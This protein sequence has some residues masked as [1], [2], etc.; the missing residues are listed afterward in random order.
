M[1]ERLARKHLALGTIC[2]WILFGA[3][4]VFGFGTAGVGSFTGGLVFWALC[5]LMLLLLTIKRRTDAHPVPP[6]A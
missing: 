2:F 3:F 5:V 6:L 1:S 4:A